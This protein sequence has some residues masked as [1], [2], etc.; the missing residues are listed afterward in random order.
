MTP[1]VTCID[2]ARKHLGLRKHE[3]QLR[4]FRSAKHETQ[5]K[6]F[7]LAKHEMQ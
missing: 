3:M 6:I 7:D 1:V 2:L 5:Q 4:R